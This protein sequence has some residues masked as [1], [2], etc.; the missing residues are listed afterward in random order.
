[1][2]TQ[3]IAPALRYW[4]GLWR[5]ENI[6]CRT[7]HAI[8]QC[9]PDLEEFFKLSDK[10]RAALGFSIELT[11]NWQAV[12]QDLTWCAV[13]PQ[14]TILTCQDARYPMRLKQIADF[15]PLLFIKGDLELL[16][17]PQIAMVGSR[18][19]TP[20]GQQTAT[21]FAYQLASAGFTI[22]SGLALGIDAASHAG[23][24]AA[25]G[26]TIAVCGTSLEHVYPKRHRTLAENIITGGGVL[27]SEFPHGTPAL[28]ENFPRRN[29]MIS[30]LSR[31]VLVVEAT[32][33]SGS[34]ITARFANE[35]GR[36]VF[37]IPGS[38]H[39]PLAHGCHAL[40]K[41]GAKL[42]ETA[43]DI[44][45]ELLPVAMVQ[46]REKQ[47]PIGLTAIQQQLF[48]CIGFEPISLD[49]LVEQSQLSSRQVSA[50]I[51]ELQLAGHIVENQTGYL[52]VQ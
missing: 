7:F 37:A 10:A 43:A 3:E 51:I 48:N 32:T 38:I 52:R 4:L 41:Q 26:K 44:F 45:E 20:S 47:K 28:A 1:M 2:V 29:R 36:E 34:L 18:N 8:L 46:S 31:G 39:N 27:L 23:A 22:T 24:L 50:A 14:H 19:P 35:Q 16:N 11:T 25:K 15:P 17:S 40:I 30:G 42:V 9:F 33:R 13:S 21:E 5:A 12:E 49:R 6:G